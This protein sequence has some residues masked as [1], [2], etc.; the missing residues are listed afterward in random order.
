MHFD[1]DT[2]PALANNVAVLNPDAL[3]P[4]TQQAV[5]EILAEGTSAN[6]DA[7]YR[8]ALRYWAAWFAL[9]YRK[10]LKFPVPVPAVIQFIVDHAQRTTAD[11]LR[12]DLPDALDEILVEKGYKAKIGPMA[13]STLNH[14]VSVLSSLHKRSPEL[15]NPCRSPAVRDLIART[16]RSYAKR[17][18]RPRGKAALTRELL[19]QLVGTCDDSLKGLRDRAILLLGWASG[20]RRRSE[21]VSLRVEDL[22]R[23]GADEFIFELGASKTNQSGTVKADDLKPVVGAA[24]SALADWLAATGLASG[25][26]FR[27]IGKNGNLRGALSASAVRTIV[28]ERCLLAGLDGDFSAHSLR[29]GF[30][31]EAAKQQIPLGETM[32]LTGHRSIPSVM[33]YFRAG[34]VTTSKAAKLFDEGDKTK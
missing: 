23:I 4:M 3:A 15:E 29:S 16:R 11:G 1:D 6:T 5:D 31:T 21:I 32:A 18:E 9:R 28:Q 26:L 24:G 12:C 14:R 27:Q 8:A 13:L 22:K 7:S 25:P 19:E 17:G 33:R 2:L 20:G 34:S 10:P 30:V